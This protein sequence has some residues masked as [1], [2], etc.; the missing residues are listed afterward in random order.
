MA[1]LSSQSDGAFPAV[2][3]GGVNRATV[4]QEQLHHGN[5]V[6]P[7]GLEERGNP[8]LCPAVLVGIVLEEELGHFR[9]ALPAGHEQG[10]LPV[11]VRGF[12]VGSRLQQQSCHAHMPLPGGLHEWS[13]PSL[14]LMV[15]VGLLA[16]E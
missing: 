10:A 5:V 16:D 3:E 2:R 14:G 4:V 1:L 9:V 6:L 7:T 8:R 11:V 12:Y 15:N 13:T